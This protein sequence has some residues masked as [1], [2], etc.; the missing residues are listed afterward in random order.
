MQS[1]K[2]AALGRLKRIEG[3]VRGISKMIEEERYCVDVLL[4]TAA[5]RAAMKGVE[6]L[7]LEDHA[8]HCV[9]DAIQSGD[10]G[11]QRAKFSELI[12]ILQTQR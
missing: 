3:Q 7:I 4:Q 8:A 11:E 2:D 5:I 10:P 9:E 1:N 12:E 6:K